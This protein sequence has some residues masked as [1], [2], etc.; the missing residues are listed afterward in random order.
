M[1]QVERAANGKTDPRQEVAEGLF[2]IHTRLSQNTNKTL[3][4]SAFLYGL[5]ELLHEKGL[6]S[7]EELEERKKIVAERLAAYAGGGSAAW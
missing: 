7:I 6:I 5:I 3:E 1:I 2:Y 4:S